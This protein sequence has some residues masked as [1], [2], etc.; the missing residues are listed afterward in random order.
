[1]RASVFVATSLDGYIAREDDRLDWLDRANK[2]VPAGE[3]CGFAEFLADTDVL[4]IGRKSFDF[5][6]GLGLQSWPY[7]ARRVVVLSRRPLTDLPEAL[8]ARIE[9]SEEMP[10]ALLS[11]LTR[12]G[13]RHAYVDGGLTVQRFLAADLIDDLTLTLVPVLLGAGKRLFAP[14][15]SERWLSAAPVKSWPF[16]FVQL[17]YERP[18]GST[19]S[20]GPKIPRA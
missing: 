4:I 6:L 9:R 14:L 12:E 15:A 8:A 7:G 18:R 16:G 13:L 11:R 17:R 20:A 10:A 3:D 1:M 19:A 2:S 5:V